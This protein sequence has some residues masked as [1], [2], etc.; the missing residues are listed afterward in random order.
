M[1]LLQSTNYKLI[2]SKMIQEIN[3][4]SWFPVVIHSGGF[5]SK[6][7]PRTSDD[8]DF[9]QNSFCEPRISR[10]F[11]RCTASRGPQG[12]QNSHLAAIQ[13]LIVLQL[14]ASLKTKRSEKSHRQCS[15]LIRTKLTTIL[16]KKTNKNTP[17]YVCPDLIKLST[18][19]QKGTYVIT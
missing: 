11:I 8:A 4:G 9:S 7:I 15:Q 3:H 12:P 19:G 14:R 16:K 17:N 1:R 18:P 13:M 2:T 6:F 5:L 10:I